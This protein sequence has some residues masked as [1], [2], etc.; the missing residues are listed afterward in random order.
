MAKKNQVVTH[1]S[2]T[3]GYSG[4]LPLP[5]HFR[6]YEEILP[7][8][9]ERIL[10]LT[11]KQSA[12]RQYLEKHVAKGDGRRAW[13]GLVTGGLL[14]GGC[15]GGGIWLVSLGHATGGIAISTASVVS[16]AS[17]FVYGSRSRRLERIQ[18]RPNPRKRK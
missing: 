10:A 14:A 17:V 1:Q 12:H 8:A 7:G 9:A 15:I 2:M 16:L 3:A 18:Q 4:P 5:A 6:E 13:A 11:E